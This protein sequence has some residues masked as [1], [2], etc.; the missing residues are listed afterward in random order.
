MKLEKGALCI[1]IDLEMAWGIWDKITPASERL[2]EAADRTVVRRLIEL[3]DHYETPVTWAIV[4][5]LF[6]SSPAHRGPAWFAPECLDWIREARVVHDI[7]SHSYEHIY[8]GECS[9]Q[10]AESDLGAARELHEREGLRFD[11]FVFP[12]NQMNHIPLLRE[13]G[14]R[15]FRSRDAGF[16]QL[17]GAIAPKLR[18]AANLIDKMVPFQAVAVTPISH[19]GLVE[20]P[21]SL[22][23]LGRGGIRRLIGPGALARKSRLTM[24]SAAKRKGIFHLWFHPSNFYDQTDVQ[25]GVIENILIAACKLRDEGVLDVRPM[26]EFSGAELSDPTSRTWGPAATRF[27]AG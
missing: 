7:G 5:R 15:V 26:S 21:S 17:V 2:I 14:V 18:S 9:A 24:R 11:S 25:F 27:S 1:S 4:G 20:L 16:V 12:R 6:D 10:A 22:L 23:L 8:F 19:A 3:F 13:S